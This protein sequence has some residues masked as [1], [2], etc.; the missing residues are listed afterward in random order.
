M[1]TDEN[2]AVVKKEEK[3]DAA[4]QVEHKA[5]K[6]EEAHRSPANDAHGEPVSG[7]GKSAEAATSVKR[8]A[9]DLAELKPGDAGTTEANGGPAEKRPKPSPAKQS[10]LDKAAAAKGQR[11]MSAFFGPRK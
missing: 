4:V 9:E 10:P 6:A 5:V 1:N 8:K 7:G 11:T 3:H 2:A